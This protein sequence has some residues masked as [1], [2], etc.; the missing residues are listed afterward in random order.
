MAQTSLISARTAGVPSCLGAATLGFMAALAMATPT[1]A[2]AAPTVEVVLSDTFTEKLEEDYG[3]REAEIVSGIVSRRLERQLPD[4]VAR[5]EVTILDAVPNRPTMLQLRNTPGLS[6][7]SFGIG[8]AS[9]EGTA[10]DAAGVPIGSVESK[11][12]ENDIS[13]S[14][15]QTTWGDLRFASSR[16]ARALDKQVSACLSGDESACSQPAE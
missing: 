2:E 10:F 8:G 14:S 16:F 1:T 11:W 12:Y 7:Q 5:V 6:L 9:F 15:F 13:D 4:S 3:T